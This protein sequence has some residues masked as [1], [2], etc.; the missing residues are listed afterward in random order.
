MMPRLLGW[1]CGLLL[2]V[3]SGCGAPTPGQPPPSMGMFE[4]IMMLGFWL[5]IAACIAGVCWY[6][7][8][9]LWYYAR[10]GHPVGRFSK[11]QLAHL[12]KSG[13]LPPE[14]PVRQVRDSR[15]YS[16]VLLEEPA[17]RWP[18]AVVC[19]VLAGVAGFFA[20]YGLFGQV[21]GQWMP[22]ELIFSG[23]TEGDLQVRLGLEVGAMV[24]S[25]AAPAA[26]RLADHVDH[27]F[28]AIEAMRFRI[29]VGTALAV[30]AGG[31]LGGLSVPPRYRIVKERPMEVPG[32]SGAAAAV[33][34]GR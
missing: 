21:L 9:L 31:V 5:T 34:P 13:Q 20:S 1:G 28:A 4:F 25:P 32:P 18:R 12:F 6:R 24:P 27:L 30:L 16:G 17:R 19:G 7:Y 15:W 23:P 33:P 14:T 8:R 3:S 11:A 26:A 22:I 2:V 10:D 29:L